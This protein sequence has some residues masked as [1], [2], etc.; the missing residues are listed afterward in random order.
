MS[1]RSKF[2]VH[3]PCK[4]IN[5]KKCD[6]DA[7]RVLYLERLRDDYLNGVFAQPCEEGTI[8]GMKLKR[9][10]RICFTEIRLSQTE[11]HTYRYGKLGIGFDRKFI[12]NRGGRPV[13]YI[14]FQAKNTLMEETIRYVYD[15]S[16]GT[17]RNRLRWLF[18][19]VKRMSDKPTTHKDSQDFLEELEWRIVYGEKL[20]SGD[21]RRMP[22][23]TY[24]WVFNPEDVRLL[25]F[26][27][28]KAKVAA[29]SDPVL[30]PFFHVHTPIMLTLEDCL[31][32]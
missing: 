10:V 4:D 8:R 22:D 21:F 32:F 9:L 15:N 12:I 28:E 23:G 27:D 26:P 19:F 31:N 7:K 25:V 20:D 6:D 14:P 3:W 30:Q 29:L 17:V 16:Q 2:L 11:T 5:E 13:I 18:A 24:R 1:T